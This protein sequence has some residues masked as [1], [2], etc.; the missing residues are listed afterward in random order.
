M[1][2]TDEAT[3]HAESTASQQASPTTQANDDPPN[4]EAP[5]D[6]GRP[7]ASLQPLVYADLRRM[8]EPMG[9]ITAAGVVRRGPILL[10]PM[11]S[12]RSEQP[13]QARFRTR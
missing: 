1:E 10:A 5:A 8:G 9:N 6:C 11:L 3:A 12:L 4:A 2:T 7:I 13:A